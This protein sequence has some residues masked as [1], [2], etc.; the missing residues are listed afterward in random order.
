MLRPTTRTQPGHRGRSTCTNAAAKGWG[1]D[2]EGALADR[3]VLA[4]QFLPQ[5]QGS[6]AP[7]RS[8]T[9]AAECQFSAPWQPPAS[10][11]RLHKSDDLR[12]L[13]KQLRH[14]A[15]YAAP[16]AGLPG[17]ALPAPTG[18]PLRSGLGPWRP[19][20]RPLLLPLSPLPQH[21]VGAA[22]PLLSFAADVGRFRPVG[23]SG[24]TL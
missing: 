3:H 12:A 22:A 17:F 19:N 24:A 1:Y 18:P 13:A 21:Q 2:P 10:G 6:P 5:F 23:P 16:P 7:R 15:A 14:A 9:A 11:R 8:N 20:G 4:A